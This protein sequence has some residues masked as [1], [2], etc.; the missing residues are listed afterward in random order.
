MKASA[1]FVGNFNCA[2]ILKNKEKLMIVSEHLGDEKDLLNFI[3]R[4]PTMAANRLELMKGRM[5]KQKIACSSFSFLIVFCL[6]PS[7]VQ[8]GSYKANPR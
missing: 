7:D 5:M 3:A 2:L 6:K 8:I 1:E 4:F